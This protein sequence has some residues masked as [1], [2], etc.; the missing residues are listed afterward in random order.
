MKGIVGVVEPM[1]LLRA[2]LFACLRE[3]EFAVDEPPDPIQW[4]LTAPPLP[5]RALVM[6]SRNDDDL[7]IVRKVAASG[8][9]Q[10][11]ALVPPETEAGVVRALAAGAR[12]VAAIDA[13]PEQV[14]AAV[15]AALRGDVM[16]P[17]FAHERIANLFLVDEPP[18][19]VLEDI[20]RELLQDLWH[21]DSVTTIARRRNYSARQMHRALAIMYVRMGVT[22][23]DAAV[24]RA[25]RWGSST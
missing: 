5:P 24:A 21:G 2:G 20:D 6:A 15:E 25:T 13:S 10:I 7:R 12:S 16:L 8:R 22:H 1:P 3:L 11:V 4:A 18:A 19:T 9:V 14:A 23:R 17:G